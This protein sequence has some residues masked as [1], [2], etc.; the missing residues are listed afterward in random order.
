MEKLTQ[1]KKEYEILE[2]LKK[3]EDSQ[4]NR[5]KKTLQKNNTLLAIFEDVKED[6]VGIWNKYQNKAMHNASNGSFATIFDISC[7]TC[8]SASGGDTQEKWSCNISH[9]LSDKLLV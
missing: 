8:Y 9:T 2:Q 3:L 4:T 6:V 5:I 7:C 1:F